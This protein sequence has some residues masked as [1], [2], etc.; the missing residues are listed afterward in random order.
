MKTRQLF[1]NRSLIILIIQAD[2]TSSNNQ[3]AFTQE[4]K[5][6]RL[7]RSF[8]SIRCLRLLSVKALPDFLSKHC[9]SVVFPFSELPN[10][11]YDADQ[12]YWKTRLLSFGGVGKIHFPPFAPRNGLTLTRWPLFDGYL[13][14]TKIK[15]KRQNLQKTKIPLVFGIE[16]NGDRLW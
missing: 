6:Y 16:N 5:R 2:V 8:S 4:K 15:M 12:I 9:S 11:S 3:F 10:T 13:Q 7:R 1:F 14:N